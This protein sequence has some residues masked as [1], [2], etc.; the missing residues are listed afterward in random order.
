MI[1][2]VRISIVVLLLAGLV[3]FPTAGQEISV[4]TSVKSGYAWR[5][6]TVSDVPV[7]QPRIAFTGNYLYAEVWGNMELADDNNQAFEFNEVQYTLGMER[8]WG[9]MFFSSGLIHYTHPGMDTADTTEV[10]LG[11]TATTRFSPTVIIYRDIHEIEGT[12]IQFSLSHWIPLPWHN[13]DGLELFV[14]AGYGD[15]SYKEGHFGENIKDGVSGQ[16][17]GSGHGD[18][19]MRQPS[20]SSGLADYGIG[21]ELPVRLGPGMLRFSILYTNLAD[22]DM[23]SPRFPDEDSRL[24]AGITYTLRF[25]LNR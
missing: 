4:E 20:L 5:G 23:H 12:Y 10:Y 9:R 24:V 6:K 25:P 15:S 18:G 3:S 16:G 19:P 14:M 1:Q 8:Q 7:F 11:V 2:G 21:M 13:T 22:S 17:P